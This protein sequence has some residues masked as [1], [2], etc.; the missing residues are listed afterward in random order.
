VTSGELRLALVDDAV[1]EARFVGRVTFRDA[2]FEARADE[3]LYRPSAGTL[4]LRG[5]DPR[6]RPR[7]EDEQIAVESDAIDV[8]LDPRQIAARGS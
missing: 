2:P 4:D 3:I 7:V 1:R 5:G 8:R 6:G